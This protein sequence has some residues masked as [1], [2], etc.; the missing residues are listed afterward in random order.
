MKQFFINRWTYIK[1]HWLM[2]P[3]VILMAGFI[4]NCWYTG[5]WPFCHGSRDV[6]AASPPAKVAKKP[7]RAA[8]PKVA[9]PAPAADADIASDEPDDTSGSTVMVTLPTTSSKTLAEERLAGGTAVGAAL[10]KGKR[11]EVRAYVNG[12]KFKPLILWCDEVLYQIK[13][14]PNDLPEDPLVSVSRDS[15]SLAVN[16]DDVIRLKKGAGLRNLKLSKEGGVEMDMTDPPTT[17]VDEYR[18]ATDGRKLAYGRLQIK[19]CGKGMADGEML[20]YFEIPAIQDEIDMDRCATTMP[21][22]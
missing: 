4:G 12:P 16:V 20:C 14:A 19:E 11:L 13:N 6:V 21:S 9:K 8:A 17:A 5:G 10:G 2:V 1:A 7:V 18:R 22:K 3:L 15:S